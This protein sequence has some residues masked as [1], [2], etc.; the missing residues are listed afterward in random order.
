[1]VSAPIGEHGAKNFETA[2]LVAPYSIDPLTIRRRDYPT[3]RLKAPD[4]FKN[5][6]TAAITAAD[7]TNTITHTSKGKPPSF[8]SSMGLTSYNRIFLPA[9][10]AGNEAANNKTA[11]RKRC[12]RI[13][14]RLS[15]V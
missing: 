2:V 15:C 10:G 4:Y 14:A 11:V 3:I 6:T 12:F 5:K 13:A 8:F 9:S 7:K 1:M